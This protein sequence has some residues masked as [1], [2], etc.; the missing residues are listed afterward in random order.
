VNTI[1]RERLAPGLLTLT[2]VDSQACDRMRGVRC[3]GGKSGCKHCVLAQP[4][5]SKLETSEKRFT[6]LAQVSFA[7]IIKSAEPVRKSPF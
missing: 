2:L 3:N 4:G 7:H 5:A 6:T 1:P